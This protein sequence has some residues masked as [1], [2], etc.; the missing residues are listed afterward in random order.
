MTKDK[1]T[2]DA[3]SVEPELRAQ[4]ELFGEDVLAHAVGAGELSSKGPQLDKLLHERR[5]EMIK[6]LREKRKKRQRRDRLTFWIVVATFFAALA[7]AIEPFF[8]H[9]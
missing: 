7:A 4:F 6:W 9:L 1:A 2:D 5:G 8:V 3:E